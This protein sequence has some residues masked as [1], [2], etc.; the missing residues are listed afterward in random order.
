MRLR[1]PPGRPKKRAG[2]RT[3]FWRP[4]RTSCGRRSTR[5]L[6][7]ASLLK[8][9]VIDPALAKPLE[10]IHRNA[11]A[12][13]KIIDDILDVSRVITG[14]FR[15]ETE[16]G[17]SVTIARD[18]I[19]VVR[20]SAAAKKLTIEFSPPNRLLSAGRGSRALATSRLESAV[21]CSEVH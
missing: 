5:L 16:A 21:E 14:K 12:Q 8:D 6:G 15:L 1:R 19:E 20:P 7:W 17:R 9:R 3:S 4:S 13:V 10:V 11:Q 2:Q 18:A